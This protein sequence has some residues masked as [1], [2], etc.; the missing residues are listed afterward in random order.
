MQRSS[1]AT[2]TQIEVQK[3]Q[4]QGC[5]RSTGSTRCRAH[6]SPRSKGRLGRS[7]I[8]PSQGSRRQGARCRRHPGR[9]G[10]EKS[11]HLRRGHPDQPG[12]DG[13][14]EEEAERLADQA[15]PV[16]IV[17]AK[18]RGHDRDAKEHEGPP[19]DRRRRNRRDAVRVRELREN[20]APRARGPRSGPANTGA[21]QAG[22]PR[23]G[24]R[25]IG[26]ASAAAVDYGLAGRH[27]VH[28]PHR[29]HRQSASA[30]ASRRPHLDESVRDR[31]RRRAARYS[32]RERR[33]RGGDAAPHAH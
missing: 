20:Q 7:P 8:L 33:P 22:L 12:D 13:R 27:D 6:A 11:V 10:L 2:R 3:R 4:E 9:R 15:R 1:T 17:T 28:D 18:R 21:C 5:P 14:I 16:G 30:T 26:S 19:E 24:R 31:H 25:V 32:Y 23:A 29:D